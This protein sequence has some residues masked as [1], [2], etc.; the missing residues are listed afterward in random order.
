MRAV[1]VTGFG[2]FADHADNPSAQAVTRLVA[3][4]APPAE[5]ALRTAVLPVSFRRAVD[6]LESLIARHRPAVVVGVGLAAGAERIALERVAVNLADARIPDVDGAQ[7]VDVPVLPG[8]PT[9]LLAT[10]PVK[11]VRAALGDAG[12]TADLSLSAGSYVCNAV[13]YAG[14][15]RAGP[16]A[17]TGFVHV[18]PADVVPVGEVAR[19]LG[20]LL[21]TVLAGGAELAVPGGRDH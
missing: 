13:M 15:T 2:P 1:L 5:V 16:G 19:A 18:P 8:G 10:L 21:D 6:E 9:A 7:P 14:L 20:V 3:S 17:P 11:A 4:W 12:I